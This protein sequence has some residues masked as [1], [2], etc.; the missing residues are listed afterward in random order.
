MA[1][2]QYRMDEGQGGWFREPR[3]HREAALK[4]KERSTHARRARP[5]ADDGS[6]GSVPLGP[7]DKRFV[8]FC[9]GIGGHSF[10]TPEEARA[11]AK[12]RY[13]TRQYDDVEVMDQETEQDI[14]RFG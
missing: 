2:K 3:P 4:G 1:A 10:D 12:K 13:A 5:P 7:D 6:S 8:V 9:D 11:F 14:A